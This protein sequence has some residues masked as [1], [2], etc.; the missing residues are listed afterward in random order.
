MSNGSGDYLL[1]SQRLWKDGGEQRKPLGE[2]KENFG[3]DGV[4]TLTL[5]NIVR[6]R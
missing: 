3:L 5:I 1:P 6:I 4:L 2:I